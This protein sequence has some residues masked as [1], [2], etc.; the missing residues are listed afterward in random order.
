MRILIYTGYHNPSWNP[1]TVDFIGLGGTEQCVL[2]LAKQFAMDN[3]V[4]VVGD[5]IEGV[6]DDVSYLK[7]QT[8]IDKL[9]DRY[10][11]CV[12]GVSYINYLL[13]LENLNFDHSIFWVHNTDFY[14]WHKGKK[15]ED[16]G[17]SLLVNEKLTKIVC[18]TDW[19]K[20]TFVDK[21]PEVKNKVILIGNGVATKSFVSSEEKTDNSFIYSSHAE[22]GLDTVLSEW[23]DI[24]NKIPNATLHI[25]TPEYGLDYFNENFKSQVE[26]MESV[27]FYGSLS[28]T[29]L[30]E[31]MAKCEFWYYPTKYEETFCIT[32]LEILGHKVK[33]IA[34]KLAGLNETLGEYNL[35]TLNNIENKIDFN[36]VESYIERCDWSNIKNLWK[37]YILEMDKK[38]NKTTNTDILQLDCVYVISL[39]TK[40]DL[41]EGWTSEIRT[42][43]LPWYQ[44]PIVCKKG[45]NGRDVTESWLSENNYELYDKWKL[46]NHQNSYWSQDM[47]H[48]E[49]G[50]AVSHHRVWVH[51]HKN[52]FKN[53]LILE[54]DFSTIS[55]ISRSI[56]KKVPRDYD[57]FY[58]GRNPL[59]TWWNSKHEDVPVGD[60]EI[61]KPAPSFN[62][63]AYMLSQKGIQSL[64]DQNF[65]TYL[66]P[67]DDFF[68]ACS[69]GH[70]RDDLKFIYNDL[71]AYALKN[72]YVSQNRPSEDTGPRTNEDHR[73]HSDLYSYWDNPDE[74]KKKFIAYSTRT[75][76]WELIIDEPFDN[77]FSMPL[78]TQEFCEKIREEA[79]YANAWTTDRHEFYPTTDML[80]DELDMTEI[81]YEVLK[82]YVIP[83]SIFA[84][85]LDGNGWDDMESEDFLAKYTP[86][87]QGHLSLHHDH[88]NITALVTLSNFDE[89]EGGGTYFSHQK[90]LIKE[91][92]GC[93][94]IHPGNITHKHGAR[95]TTK[96][97]R[98]I[99]VSFM[100]NTHFMK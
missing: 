17:R 7:T 67:V 89:Y 82:E 66:F 25:A 49:I 80:L 35:E 42:K 92:Q 32:A 13:E 99:I 10:I 54:E 79:E 1:S 58:L 43:L 26:K 97:I 47:T 37:K 5:V 98:Y 90:K 15:L 16:N 62:A 69:T 39:S 56:L 64:I 55:T 74:W 23:N 11:D 18:L 53:I 72:D 83:A 81:Y 3:E 50:C 100:K 41:L 19:H 8:A 96:G 78:F 4:F 34:S 95:A 20:Q 88:S 77:C 22:R 46:E 21:F 12:I 29:E 57:L 84:F 94:S 86:N 36:S 59:Y 75:Q 61:V 85:Q 51:A 14:P 52:K 70:D 68:I 2:N 87:A 30:Y 48:G 24:K 31:L 73:K 76:E 63:H 33:P 91:K 40:E 9:G 93:V 60:G 45:L 71:V 65:H 44:G 38:H 27:K 6:Y 28:R